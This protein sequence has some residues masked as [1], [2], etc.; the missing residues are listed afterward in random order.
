MVEEE[1]KFE[2]LISRQFLDWLGEQFVSLAF[3]TYQVGKLF[4]LGLQPSGRLEVFNRTFNRSMAL[5]VSAD[6]LYMSSLYQL[7]R[8]QN[9]LSVGQTF[10]GYDRVYVPQVAWTT[11][12]IDIHDIG[13]D[14]AGRPVFVNT[15]FSCLATVSDT[16]SFKPV[17][18]PSF[19][20]KLA[21]E[22]RCHMNGAAFVDGKP[23]FVTLVAQSDLTDGWREHRLNGGVVYD[24]SRN[25][26][27]IEG[28]SMPHSPRMYRDKLWLLDSGN[29]WF[30]YADLD[31][32]KFEKVTFCPGYARGLAF[33]GDYA[34]IGLSMPRDNRTFA[35]LRL[36]L[37]LSSK[38][39]EARCGL[40][41]VD[42]RSGDIVHWLRITGIINELFDAA[43]LPGFIRPMAIG[44]KT[45]EIRRVLSVEPEDG[46]EPPRL[47]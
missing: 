31:K 11:G 2:V 38:H 29:G 25:E 20:S 4:F 41:I 42:L 15:L 44:L 26:P 3:T 7:W 22:D 8:F 40:L 45:D 9:A 1:A 37:E 35:G 16:H 39:A 34:I 14:T 21:A 47:N 10:N 33:Y 24:T 6:T 32:G 23:R 30:G 28:L 27:V 46:R 5:Y 12:D 36:D 18:Q 19:I 17:W 13:L 43:V